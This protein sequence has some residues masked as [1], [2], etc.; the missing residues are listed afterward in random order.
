MNRPVLIRYFLYVL[1]GIALLWVVG[2]V[3]GFYYGIKSYFEQ[4]DF[5]RSM[6][7][8]DKR[9]RDDSVFYEKVNSLTKAKK[10]DEAILSFRQKIKEDSVGNTLMLLS[11]VDVYRMKGDLSSAYKTATEYINSDSDYLNPKSVVG[12]EA[13]LKRSQISFQMHNLDNVIKD[14]KI[15]AGKDYSMYYLLG[16]VQAK[17]GY[18]ADAKT[19]LDSAMF[20]YPKSLTVKLTSDSIN[21][22]IK[23]QKHKRSQDS[24]NLK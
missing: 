17:K 16:Q 7:L 13:Y 11:L 23:H 24:I 9:Q 10:Y 14:L 22:L 2:D 1:F 12:A 5:D 4:R 21:D 18:L 3:L 20:Y 8:H 19:S 6:E 15:A